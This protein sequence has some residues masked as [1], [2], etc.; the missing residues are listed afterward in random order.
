V[1]FQAEA[2]AGL[3]GFDAQAKAV[4]R[5]AGV[6][7]ADETGV[8]AAG[9]NAWLHVARAGRATRLPA[10]PGRGRQAMDGAGI[11]PGFTEV[12]VHD[13]FGSCDT[14]PETTN[15]LCGAHLP[16]G[17][18]AVSDF[19]E[20]RPEHRGPDGWDWAAQASAAPPAVKRAAGQAPGRVCPPGQLADGRS[21]QRS[22]A[23]TAARA[24]RPPPARSGRSAGLWPAGS[25]AGRTAACG[26]RFAR[27]PRSTT[28][29][30]NETCGR[31]NSG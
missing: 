3:A 8:R 31:R 27:T 9:A 18:Q 6:L 17:L 7:G 13:A 10:H 22:A 4:V 5:Q 21:R 2:A 29:G 19:L 30:R 24:D 1:D 26:P 14:F 11:P 28:T 25:P 15:Q 23:Q 12:L 16:R 20:A